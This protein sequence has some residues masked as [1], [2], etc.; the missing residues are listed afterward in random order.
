MF[1]LN[2]LSIVFLLA[3]ALYLREYIT[4]RDEIFLKHES[5]PSK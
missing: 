4:K 3:S 2:Y 1:L 5:K